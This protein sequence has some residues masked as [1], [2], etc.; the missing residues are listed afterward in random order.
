MK[1]QTKFG[2]G[3]LIVF[4]LLAVSIATTSFLWVDHTTIRDAQAR[5][6]LHIQASWEIFN[7]KLERMQAAM[8]VL[9]RDQQVREFLQN[10]YDPNLALKTRIYLELLRQ[11]QSMDVLNVMD[12]TGRVLLRTRAPHLANDVVTDDPVVSR[13][14][15][16]RKLA[17]GT[18]ILPPERL[19]REGDELVARC[20]E[21][22]GELRGMMQTVA[23]P[24]LAEDRLLGVV[25]VGSLVNGASEKVDRIRNTVFQNAQYNGKPLGTA[26]IFMGD[27]R[28]STNVLDTQGKRAVGTR[29]SPEVAQRVLVEGKPWTGRAWVVDTWYLAQ[30]DPLYDPDGRIIGMLYVGELEQKYLDLRTQALALFLAVIFAGM[31]LAFVIFFLIVRSIVEPIQQLA[32]ATQRLAAGDL[33]YRIADVPRGT[34]QDEVKNLARSFNAM[35]EELQQQRE[36]IED[37]RRALEKLNEDLQTTNRNYMEMLGFVAHELK[38]PLS[39][40]IMNVH[41]VKDGYVGPLND[42][43]KAALESVAKSLRYFREMIAN[44]LDLSRLEKGELRVKPIR[45]EL[46]SEVI[47]PIVEGL[48]RSLQEKRMTLDN[49]VPATFEL[50]ADRDLLRIVYDN[51]LSNAIKYGREG[52]KIVLSA[53]PTDRSVTLSVW[54]EGD[55]IPPDKMNLL[56]KK[57]SRIPGKSSAGKKGTGLGLY[58]CKEIIEKHGGKIWAESQVGAWT[59]FSFELPN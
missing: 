45:L 15:T 11:S 4:T 1:L 2:L 44:Y 21:N 27:V 50:R 10:S 40:A 18:I 28:I 9:A 26:T 38:N 32:Y 3:I 16:T 25:Q 56:F 47:A 13:A 24:I 36:Q 55:G 41:T 52:G 57:F 49:Q 54:N 33:T 59:K 43:Q 39:S 34:T 31:L 53:Q 37:D 23:V 19:R 22:G 46:Q 29:A 20:L 8:E 14:L 17:V 42:T 30:Y 58:I 48:A 12:S 35:A 6:Q 7:S 51:L 5:V